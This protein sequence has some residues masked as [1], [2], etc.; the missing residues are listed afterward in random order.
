MTDPHGKIIRQG[1][2]RRNGEGVKETEGNACFE[3]RKRAAKWN[4]RLKSRESA[5]ECMGI[6]EP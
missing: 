4:D 3:C 5:A 2:R 6:R 1:W